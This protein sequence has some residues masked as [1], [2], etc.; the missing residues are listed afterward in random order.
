MPLTITFQK[1]HE[2]V[3][4]TDWPVPPREREDVDLPGHPLIS[5]VVRSVQWRGPNAVLVVLADRAGRASWWEPH[6]LARLTE[7]GDV[8]RSAEL[9]GV[10][11]DGVYKARRRSH[12]LRQAWDAALASYRQNSG[13]RLRRAT[14]RA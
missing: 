11:A 10:T 1:G 8:K 4:V 12:R 7:T 6:F 5:G 14:Q 13:S 9:A 3:E 2:S